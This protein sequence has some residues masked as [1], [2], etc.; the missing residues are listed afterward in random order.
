[1]SANLRSISGGLLMLAII[2]VLLGLL[3]CMP[4]PIGDPEKSR[5]DPDLT[6]VWFVSVEETETGVLILDAYDKRTWLGVYGEPE[7]IEGIDK[8]DITSYDGLVAAMGADG[9]PWQVELTEVMIVKA[10]LTELGG[11]TFMVWQPKAVFDDDDNL[12]ADYAYNF[13][14]VKQSRDSFTLAFFAD[15]HPGFDD[16]DTEDKKQLEAAIRKN[17]K[18]PDFY[19]DEPLRL[20]RVKAAD[21]ARFDSLFSDVIME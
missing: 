14:L 5:V 9:A 4:V 11:E 1:M 10:W 13:H 12:A 7:A 18:D 6:G 20:I 17:A 19:D 21:L 3:A 15:D 16:V 8:P 2:P